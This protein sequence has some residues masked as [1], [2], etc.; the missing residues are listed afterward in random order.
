MGLSPLQLQ[1][2]DTVEAYRRGEAGNLVHFRQ[3]SVG[4]DGKDTHGSD[5]RVKRVYEL[6]IAA[7]RDVEVCGVFRVACDNRGRGE[8]GQGAALADRKSGDV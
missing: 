4:L 1:C 2:S 8:R 5:R 7:D 6:A 3:R